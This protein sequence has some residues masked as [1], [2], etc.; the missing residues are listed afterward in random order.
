MS[1]QRPSGSEQHRAIA[2]EQGGSVPIA[3]VTVSDS[4]T[5]ETDTNGIWL[6][7]QIE[8]LGHRVVG[9]ALLRDDP[10]PVAETLDGL[11]AGEARIVLV[12]GGTGIAKRDNTFD[13]ISGKLEKTLPGFG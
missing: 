9:Y 3:I 7:E 8:T 12:N 10:G 13:A 4:R 6:R 5:P 2:A 1:E 11:C